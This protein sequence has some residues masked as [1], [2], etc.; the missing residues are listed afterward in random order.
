MLSTLPLE[1]DGFTTP[2]GPD[3]LPIIMLHRGNDGFVAFSGHNKLGQFC[4]FFSV[5]ARDLPNVFTEF[6]APHLGED[7]FFSIN[8]M[9]RD[10][11]RP[12][13]VLP[14]RFREGHR[15]AGSLRWLT[16][17]YVDLDYYN[18]GAT[19]GQA[20][21]IVVDAQET[22]TIPIASMLTRSGRGLWAWW[23]LDNGHGH[24]ERAWPET[25][26]TYK[27]IQR[28][29][30]YRF[31]SISADPNAR[32]ATRITR[33]PGSIHRAASHEAGH[34]VRVG[35]WIQRDTQGRAIT[36]RLDELAV[37]LNVR[38]SRLAEGMRK[39]LNPLNQEKGRRGY[40]ALWQQRLGK[41]VSLF[42]HRQ[43]IAKGYRSRSALLLAV[44]M[45]R[46][47]IDEA[48]IHNTVF[49]FGRFQCAPPLPDEE[50]Q[51]AINQ[52]ASFSQF[53]DQTIA[54]WLDVTREEA[55]LFGW[56]AAGER[57]READRIRNRN[58]ARE[59]RRSLLQALFGDNSR[60]RVPPLRDVQRILEDEYGI[61]ATTR[62]I[63][64][65]LDKL[66]INRRR[67]VEDD[68]PKLLTE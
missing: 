61:K 41:L 43:V 24:P 66:K 35:Y 39:V 4:N 7:S 44:C 27:R 33:V 11:Y 53:C 10:G 58:D 6:L 46:N 68:Q 67:R 48:E 56:P 17:C 60:R 59:A 63:Q 12:S 28:E 20:V 32:D 22:G 37:R 9:F 45:H 57:T 49:R 15:N 54:D 5:P 38:P 50:I 64:K 65:D 29:L 31:R 25:V 30:T 14:H 1:S 3:A 26:G 62:T 8:A 16:A 13:P 2:S 19:L 21:G 51:N 23:F 47:R 40:A 52:R 18:I 34:P 55:D 36:Y 42:A